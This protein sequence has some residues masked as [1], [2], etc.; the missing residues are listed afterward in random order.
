MFASKGTFSPRL[1]N[2]LG[3]DFQKVQSEE[4]KNVL[5]LYLSPS[6]L[7]LLSYLSLH[8]SLTLSSI[9]SHLS[10]PSHPTHPLIYSCFLTYPFTSLSPSHLFLLSYLPLHIL[11]T[12]SSIPAFLLTPSH[13]SHTLIYSFFLIHPS[14]FFN[15]AT[16]RAPYWPS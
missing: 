4:V 2:F 1:F 3:I 15:A 5:L 6:H 13:L 14:I 7:F 9:P 8:I 12:L 16:R 11:H 10:T